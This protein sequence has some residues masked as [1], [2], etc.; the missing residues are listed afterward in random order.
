MR[1]DAVFLIKD[2]SNVGNEMPDLSIDPDYLRNLIVKVRA[3]MGREAKVMPDEA[4]NFTD[5]A[6]PAESLQT[7]PDD[8]SR[9]EV[10]QEIRGLSPAEQAEL[11][12]LMWLGRGDGGG[13]EWRDLV[14]RARDRREAPTE[15]YLL[16][17]PLVAEYWLEGLTQLGY[18]GLINGVEVE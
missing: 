18:G 1:R 8:L 9:E 12:A 7:G 11:V 5:D 6:L 13:E 4:S 16:D 15:S 10:V 2:K 14:Q 3:L 17:H